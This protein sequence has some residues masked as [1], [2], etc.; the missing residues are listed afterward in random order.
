MEVT[1]HSYAKIN[2]G[3]RLLGKRKDG[4]HDIETIFQLIDLNDTLVFKR[5]QSDSVQLSCSD[6]SIPLDKANL[7][8][9]AFIHYRKMMQ[10]EGGVN[11]AIEKRIPAGGGLGGGSSNAAAT[12][13]ACELLWNKSTPKHVLHRMA[14]EIGSDVPFFLSGG[15]ALG[16]GRGEDLTPLILADEFWIV[17]VCPGFSVSTKWAYSQSK[18]G[19]TNT[20]KIGTLRALFNETKVHTWRES[21]VNELESVVFTR[22]PEL[23]RIKTQFYEKDAFYASMSGSGSTMYGLFHNR[24]AAESAVTFFS[25]YKMHV[26]LA[27][28]IS[29]QISGRQQSNRIDISEDN[30]GNH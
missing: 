9:Q 17:L 30:H 12:L 18:I 27:R 26:L 22:H 3:L 8:Y 19:L 4:Y 10:I 1:L 15:T 20:Q 24:T 11:V 13:Q 16:K 29:N 7:V 25:K 6:S 2:I 5:L 14:F 21:A 28:P 23:Q